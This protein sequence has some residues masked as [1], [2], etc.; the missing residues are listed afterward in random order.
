MDDE[1]A[2]GGISRRKALKGIGAGA[3]VVWAA[4]VLT[5]LQTP[6]FAQTPICERCS[7]ILCCDPGPLCGDP[8]CVCTTDVENRCVCLDG[9]FPCGPGAGC[10]SSQACVDEFGPTFHCAVVCCT[11]ETQCVPEC[12]VDGGRSRGKGLRAG[13]RR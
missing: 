11:G 7:D 8:C 3:A 12:F 5:S 2:S 13:D 6:A 4:P 9:T 10:T 1:T